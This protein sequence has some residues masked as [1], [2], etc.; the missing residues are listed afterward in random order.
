MGRHE[1]FR[2]KMNHFRT[3]WTDED[4]IDP[5]YWPGAFTARLSSEDRPSCMKTQN[6]VVC[7]QQG[8]LLTVF[9]VL[10]KHCEQA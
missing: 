9:N 2:E 8:T 5:S 6:V 7:V 4:R 3:Q 1:P 10:A